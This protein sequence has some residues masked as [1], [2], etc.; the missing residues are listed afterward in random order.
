MDF[1]VDIPPM[2]ARHWQLYEHPRTESV[3]KMRKGRKRSSPDDVERA[4]VHLLN[5]PLSVL[6]KKTNLLH[7]GRWENAGLASE[8]TAGTIF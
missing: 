6:H 3:R 5:S 1:I 7:R 2:Q 4:G 8:W